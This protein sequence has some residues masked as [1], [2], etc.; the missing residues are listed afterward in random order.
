MKKY[1]LKIILLVIVIL[2]I[3]ASTSF[4]A[5]LTD[6]SVLS[7]TL[8]QGETQLDMQIAYSVAS[9]ILTGDPYNLKWESLR[10]VG[11]DSLTY[12]YIPVRLT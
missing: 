7:Q 9:E 12:L 10:Y 11:L 5:R 3:S 1:L 6:N 4:A 2:L 8:E